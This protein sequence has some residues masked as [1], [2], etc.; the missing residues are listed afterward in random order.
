MCAS[1]LRSLEESCGGD[2]KEASGDCVFFLSTAGLVGVQ[3]LWMAA[4][5]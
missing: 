1:T 5:K 2:S 4:V 3:A